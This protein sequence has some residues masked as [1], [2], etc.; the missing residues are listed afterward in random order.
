MAEYVDTKLTQVIENEMTLA[1]YKELEKAGLIDPNQKYYLTDAVPGEREWELLI[2]NTT[3]E[4]VAQ[5]KYSQ[6]KDGQVFSE[7]SMFAIDIILQPNAGGKS[8][9]EIRCALD[10][11]GAWAGASRFTLGKTATTA[12]VYS[13]SLIKKTPIG[14]M[15]YSLMS[16]NQTSV[17]ALLLSYMGSLYNALGNNRSNN[18][19][20]S[21]SLNLIQDINGFSIGTYQANIGA[22]SRLRIY[23]IK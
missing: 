20:P 10:P 18:I 6:G 9:T 23:G 11:S 14:F 21:T 16:A 1:R 2:D 7:Y 15:V 3:T 17:S 8:A 19:N 13:S 5:W 22:D 12:T 4:D